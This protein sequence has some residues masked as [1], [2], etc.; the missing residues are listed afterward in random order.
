MYPLLLVKVTLVIV[1]TGWSTEDFCP[2]RVNV[3]WAPE[4]IKDFNRGEE[5]SVCDPKYGREGTRE[6]LR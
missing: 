4:G 2:V 6:W 1:G 5:L 3:H